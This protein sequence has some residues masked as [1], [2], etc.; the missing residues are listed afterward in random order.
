MWDLGCK[1]RQVRILKAGCSGLNSECPS[2]ARALRSCLAASFRKVVGSDLSRK[3]V[4][5]WSHNFVCKCKYSCMSTEV[6]VWTHACVGS[7]GGSQR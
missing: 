6:C 7:S 4:H 1:E 3:S 5:G 2:K